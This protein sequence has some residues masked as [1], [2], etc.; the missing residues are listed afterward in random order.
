MRYQEF[1]ETEE[2]KTK[3]SYIMNLFMQSGLFIGALSTMGL[4]SMFK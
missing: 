4:I 3:G 1:L 2:E